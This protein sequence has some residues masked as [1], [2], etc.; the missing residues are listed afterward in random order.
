MCAVVRK[1]VESKTE[2]IILLIYKAL[3]H[4]QGGCCV[5][6]WSPHLKK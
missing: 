4:L 2:D 5:Q 1:G 6:L 3:V